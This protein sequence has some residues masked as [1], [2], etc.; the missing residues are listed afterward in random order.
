ML[1]GVLRRAR[2]EGKCIFCPAD[3]LE[4]RKVCEKHQWRKTACAGCLGTKG[5][6]P[7]R[8]TPGPQRRY[9]LECRPAKPPEHS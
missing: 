3:A 4:G 9:C 7:Y 1:Y 8:D 2:L 5:K 6:V